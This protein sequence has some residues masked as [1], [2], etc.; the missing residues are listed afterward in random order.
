MDTAQ[1]QKLAETIFKN[2]R[3]S[4]IMLDRDYRILAVNNP[5][6]KWT[7]RPSSD[8]IDKN[9]IDIF[10]D[11]TGICPHC[12]AKVTF[13]TGEVNI[14]TQKGT[15]KNT[16]YYAELSVYPVKNE[17]GEVIEC[18][19]FI[20]DITER[21]LSHEEILSLY[22]EVTQTKEYLEGIIENSADAIVTSDI[23]GII[24]SWNKAAE[25]IYGFSEQE[26]IGRYLPFIPDSLMSIE[27]EC[28]ERIKK[29]ETIKHI[30]TKRRKKDGTLFEV[31]L[32]LSPIKAAD[33]EVI[34]IS[35]ISRDIS[36]R[37]RIEK[38][39]IS[40][41]LEL[42][43]LFFISSAMRGTLELDKLLRM[44]LTAVTMG[45]GL[46]FNRA[47]LFLVDEEKNILKG[48]MG[49]GP[50]N[51]MDAGQIWER[52]GKK[53]LSEIIHEIEVSPLK[54]DSFFDRL[55][56]GME[57]PLSEETI[58]TKTVKEKKLFN[59]H[60][61]KKEPL[62]DVILIQQLGTEAYAVSPLISRDKVIGVIWVDN[63]FNKR[64]IA[65]EDMRFLSGF[66]NHIATAIESARL[67][68][69]VALAE[70]ELENIFESISDMVYFINKDYVLKSINKAVSKRLGKPA[71]EIIGK[72][73]YEVIHGMNG[74]L[75][76]CPHHKTIETGKAFVEEVEDHHL[77]G[78]FIFS[79]SPIFDTTGEFI[80]T[81]NVVS[82]ITE[83]KNLRERL[84][85]AE[86][87]AA[88]GEVAAKVAHEIRNPLVSLGG[89]AKRLEKKLDGN[90][91]EYADI[92]AK[93][94]ERLE[95][96]LNEILS[97]VKETRVIKEITDS[98]RIIE[99]VISLTKSDLEDRNIVFVREI[100]E[101]IEMYI[102]PNRMKEAL[103]NILKNA[104][105]AVGN[106]GTIFIKTYIKDNTA[107]V[108]IKDTGA[109]IAEE[110]LPFIFDPFFT[111]KK[112]GTGLG[113]AIT[114]RIVEEHT[115]SIEVESKPGAGSTFRVFIPLK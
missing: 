45:N 111:T 14:V 69:Q 82:D 57:I 6:E 87:M 112:T 17:T 48:A 44:V 94:V 7:G 58:L 32:T 73:C 114:H 23:N 33:G 53:T 11:I 34:G 9:C 43:R 15:L 66:S 36:E 76:E 41:N 12:A 29:G 106:N 51:P 64:P 4:I 25:K 67:Y 27:K 62:S 109:G 40:K 99:E 22:N 47:I 46:G 31:S 96:I 20:Q 52:L 26:V 72:K 74:P 2:I 103:L 10:H 95:G 88:L 80:G 102:D 78:T 77:G 49:V 115:G 108:E 59:I 61:I 50:M 101:R 89:F 70:Q 13:E 93:E 71:E 97:F 5:I 79:S 8:L 28:I 113:L 30:E 86:R 35:G 55:S 18:V 60:D 90:L 100:D 63:H 92:I 37:K 91:K 24:R 1:K 81:V 65:E 75:A 98:A 110:D 19:I 16:T 21:M 3:D 107:V 68:E 83:L 42:S 84:I 85:K 105:Q 54:K 104:V 38:E 56:I 39:L